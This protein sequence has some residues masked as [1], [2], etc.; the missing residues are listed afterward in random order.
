MQ[1]S[2]G[3]GMSPAPA[4]AGLPGLR[5]KTYQKSLAVIWRIRGLLLNV[6][7]GLLN[8]GLLTATYACT[9][10]RKVFN[11]LAL[12]ID[13]PGRNCGWLN[14]LNACPARSI[15]NRSRTLKCLITEKSMLL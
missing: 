9:F 2:E 11:V 4:R 6:L 1:R 5:L 7:V 3:K 12:L 15:L 10:P 8:N 13:P 14:T